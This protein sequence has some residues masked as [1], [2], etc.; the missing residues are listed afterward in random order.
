MSEQLGLGLDPDERTP[1]A[2]AADMMIE[3]ERA[4]RAGRLSDA[5]LEAAEETWRLARIAQMKEGQARN[6]AAAPA[7]AAAKVP[8]AMEEYLAG[9]ASQY[10]YGPKPSAAQSRQARLVGRE[11][12]ERLA[13]FK[14]SGAA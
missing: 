4:H 2:C 13:A 10:A 8:R 5:D 6:A 12:A 11:L 1:F 14:Q 7:L 9:F 3:A